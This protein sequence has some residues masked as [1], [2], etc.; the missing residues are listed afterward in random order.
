M[1]NP[2]L[3][4]RESELHAQG[5]SIEDFNDLQLAERRWIAARIFRARPDEADHRRASLI[6][7]AHPEYARF[8]IL[9]G[10]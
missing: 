5:F 6:D 1:N 3:E 2:N 4:I 7:L 9:V 8:T 10:S